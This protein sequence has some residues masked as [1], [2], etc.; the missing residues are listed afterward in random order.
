M[1][2]ESIKTA[3][4]AAWVAY[5]DQNSKSEITSIVLGYMATP[6]SREDRQTFYCGY[7]LDFL[8]ML[9]EELLKAATPTVVE[10][11]G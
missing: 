3:F 6:R 8:D 4:D 5:R 1:D 11:E 10:G 9:T 2:A 7:P